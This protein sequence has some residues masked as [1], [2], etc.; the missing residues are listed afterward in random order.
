MAENAGLDPID[1]LTELKA[2]HER[3]EAAAGINILTNRIENSFE[4][5]IIEPLKIKT[6]A[7]SSANE[8]AMMILRIDDVLASNSKSPG[9]S[10]GGFGGMPGYNE[11]S[12]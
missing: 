2:R 12:D 10:M 5:G 11:D 4:A 8:V 7:I 3:N 6:Q 9:K 1:I